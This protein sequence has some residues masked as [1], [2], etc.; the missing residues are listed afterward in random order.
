M[1]ERP[2]GKGVLPVWD[3]AGDDPSGPTVVF[4]HGWGDGRIGGL[5]RIEPFLGAASRI[6]LWDLPGHGDAPASAGPCELG[7]VEA[8]DLRALLARIDGPIVLFGWSLGAGV[9]I[10]AA[11]NE[12]RVVGVVLEAPYRLPQIPASRV[13]GARG[14]PQVGM[15]RTALMSIGGSAWL[16]DGGPFDRAAAAA[17]VRA[18]MLVLQGSD[19]PV[20]PPEGA[21]SIVRSAGANARVASIQ[22]G[23]HN[24]LWI[25]P[26]F[27]AECCSAVAAWLASLQSGPVTAPHA[28]RSR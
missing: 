3:I 25:S 14:L 13:M 20:C 16:R 7:R 4:T 9:S 2:S 6:L 27:R 21:E 12:P 17:K 26:R 10:V 8:E 19:D 11:A 18:P 28:D 15:L 5:L 1:L 23:R 22:G 24:D